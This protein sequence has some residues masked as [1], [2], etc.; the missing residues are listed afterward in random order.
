[1][2][3][4]IEE[5]KILLDTDV[6]IHFLNGSQIYILPTLFPNRLVI[7]DSVKEEL[8]RPGQLNFIGQCKIEEKSIDDYSYEIRLEYARLRRFCGK[9][10]SACMA[11]A[12]YDKE[13]ISSSNLKD[14][15][16]YCEEYGITYYT[17]MDILLMACEK[18]L[19]TEDECCTFIQTVKSKGSKLPC[20]T[21]KEYIKI[22][23]K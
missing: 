3:K 20:D 22:K 4:K 18:G 6:I 9:G 14:I 11:V 5:R 21:L 16:P 12:R 13:Y 1:M 15:K 2:T 7:L 23:N 19:L 8:T 17:T 10:E